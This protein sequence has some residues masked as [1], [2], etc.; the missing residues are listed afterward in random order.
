MTYKLS[1]Q[2]NEACFSVDLALFFLIC[3]KDKKIYIEFHTIFTIV[4]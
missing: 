1:I 4:Q 3:E 2:G